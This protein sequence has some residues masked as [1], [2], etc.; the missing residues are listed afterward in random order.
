VYVRV[1]K[2]AECITPLHSA[3]GIGF[4]VFRRR[5]KRRCYEGLPKQM[6]PSCCALRK[7]SEG[8]NAARGNA[9][10][11]QQNLVAAVNKYAFWLPVTV[12]GRRQVMSYQS[13]PRIH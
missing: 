5:S 11:K 8:F 1:H 7:E 2:H 3:G 13:S 4:S 6:R 12:V 9:E 10:G